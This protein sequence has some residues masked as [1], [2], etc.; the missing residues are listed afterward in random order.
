[1]SQSSRNCGQCHYFRNNHPDLP[2]NR[3]NGLYGL[4]Q[5]PWQPH[6]VQ[7]QDSVGCMYWTEREE[8]RLQRRCPSCGVTVWKWLVEC[9]ECAHD[10]SPKRRKVN[11]KTPTRGREHGW[12]RFRRA[13]SGY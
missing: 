11:V 2:E 7:H 5:S 9:P 4:C 12:L 6:H 13:H 8:E 3:C 1:V 10:L